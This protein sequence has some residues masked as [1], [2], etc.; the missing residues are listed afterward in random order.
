MNIFL[1]R[2]LAFFREKANNQSTRCVSVD[3]TQTETK[4]HKQPM[5]EITTFRG[6]EEEKYILKRASF[7]RSGWLRAPAELLDLA[8]HSQS[9]VKAERV[10]FFPPEFLRCEW[11]SEG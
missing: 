4:T 1:K 5:N 11:R 3:A 2:N 6:N 9:K 10:G 7:P 8:A